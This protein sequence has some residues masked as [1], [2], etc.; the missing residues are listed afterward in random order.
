[1]TG[2]PEPRPE[3]PAGPRAAGGAEPR[4]A[5]PPVRPGH[6]GRPPRPLLHTEVQEEICHH[7]FVQTDLDYSRYIYYKYTSHNTDLWDTAGEGNR[8]GESMFGIAILCHLVLNAYY[9]QNS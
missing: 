4:D 9:I 1:M 7:A 5:E 2:D 8:Q 3:L 6:Q